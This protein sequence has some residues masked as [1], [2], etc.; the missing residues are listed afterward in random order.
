MKNGESLGSLELSHLGNGTSGD[1]DTKE[2]A[3][4]GGDV[5]GSGLSDDFCIFK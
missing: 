5:V 1:F 3:M 4:F 2:T